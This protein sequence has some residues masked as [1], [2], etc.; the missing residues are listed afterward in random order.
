MISW[1][2][3]TTRVAAITSRAAATIKKIK[4]RPTI[5]TA[6]Q[7]GGIATIA[8]GVGLIDVAAGMIVGGVGMLL[9]GLAVE[10]GGRPPLTPRPPSAPTI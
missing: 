7:A 9:F 1:E 6:L 4:P 10:M 5:A 8:F 2:A 3:V